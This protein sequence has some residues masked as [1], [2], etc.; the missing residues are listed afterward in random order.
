MPHLSLPEEYLEVAKALLASTS[1]ILLLQLGLMPQHLDEAVWINLASYFI[2]GLVL[3]F[4]LSSK[5]KEQLAPST[6][7]MMTLA[8]SLHFYFRNNLTAMGLIENTIPSI[9]LY[10]ILSG[11]A[12]VIGAGMKQFVAFLASIIRILRHYW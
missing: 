12:L 4:W 1:F 2:G 3:S 5:H 7:V 11:L 9:L 8:W 10:N 6:L